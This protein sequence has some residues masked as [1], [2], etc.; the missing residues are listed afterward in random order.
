MSEKKNLTTVSY[1]YPSRGLAGLFTGRRKLGFGLAMLLSL[2]LLQPGLAADWNQ[3]LGPQRNGAARVP[4]PRTPW[5]EGGP[6]VVWSRDVGQGLA[7]PVVAGDRVLF[8]QR[9]GDREIVECLEAKSGRLLWSFDYQTRY[10]DDFGFDEGPR[11]TPVVAGDKVFTFGAQGVLTAASLM[12]GEK[13]WSVDTHSKFGVRKGFFGAAG[14]PVVEGGKVF[15]NI[16]GDNG[17]GL[18]CFDA[19]TGETLW[20]ATDHEASYSSPV[21]ADLGG[22]RRVLFYTRSGLVVTSLDGD[23]LF[24][25]PWRSRSRSSVNAAVPL[26]VNN[27]VF[28]SASY[29]TGGVLL[30]LVGSVLTKAWQSD[31]ALS[32]H[33]ASSVV[34]EG[35]LYGFHGRQEYGPSFRCVEWATGKVVWNQDGLGAGT[36]MLLSNQLLILTER[37]ELIQAPATPRGFLPSARARILKPVTRAYPAFS[38]GFLYARDSDRL[39]CVRLP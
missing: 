21:I 19:N 38:S 36:V 22:V 18:V 17:S 26:V 34:S 5:P 35:H 6:E 9:R 4:A 20:T 37:G 11:A 7:G 10:R 14:S 29:N 1:T 23:V 39:T 24:E 31:Q 2:G 27:E 16:G 25:F 32:S 12:T 3:L 15:A 13:L 8:F 33:Y 28:L 30:K